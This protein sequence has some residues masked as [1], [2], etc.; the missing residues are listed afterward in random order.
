MPIVQK[1]IIIK[2]ESSSLLVTLKNSD[3]KFLMQNWSKYKK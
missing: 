1:M 3:V 2:K